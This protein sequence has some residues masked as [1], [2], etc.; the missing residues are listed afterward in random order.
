[1]STTIDEAMLLAARAKA[2]SD[3]NYIFTQL[4][5]GGKATLQGDVILIEIDGEELAL[6]LDNAIDYIN[7]LVE[8]Y[9]N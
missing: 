7:A 4:E 5:S 1:M 3:L 9:A 2:V 6:T 8:K